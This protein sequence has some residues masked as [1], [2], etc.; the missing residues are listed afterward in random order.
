[1]NRN[2]IPATWDE[3]ATLTTFMDYVRATV[4]VK[5]E[6]ISEA[7]A[8]LIPLSTSPL[9]SIAGVVSHLRWVEHWWFQVIFLGQ[10]DRGPWTKDDPDREFR[11]ALE[12]PMVELLQDYEAQCGASRQIVSESDL[13]QWSARE[14]R[15]GGK[16]PLRWILFHMMEETARHNGHLDI[17]RETA[18][19]V[20]GS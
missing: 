17:L 4:H 16:V 14:M 11:I 7:N 6:G 3:R 19:G 2:D 8:R 9:M 1:M 13:D 5:C 10:D 15:R 18:D 20:I 12:T